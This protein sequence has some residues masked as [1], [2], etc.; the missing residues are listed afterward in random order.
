MN[1]TGLKKKKRIMQKYLKNLPKD[2]YLILPVKAS[3]LKC[4]KQIKQLQNKK[5]AK[6]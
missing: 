6:K 1:I 5:R 2:S 3:I 4:S